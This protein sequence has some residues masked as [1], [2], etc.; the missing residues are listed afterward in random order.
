MYEAV[1]PMVTS[2][3]PLLDQKEE[4]RQRN[5]LCPFPSPDA[6]AAL[7]VVLEDSKDSA[8]TEAAFFN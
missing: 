4:R 1:D 3:L 2:S 8:R 5:W 7:P 6:T